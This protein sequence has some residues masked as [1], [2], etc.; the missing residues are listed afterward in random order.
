MISITSKGQSCPGT[1]IS[2]VPTPPLFWSHPIFSCLFPVI[3][4]ESQKA[5]SNYHFL[6]HNDDQMIT[7]P[8]SSFSSL[9]LSCCNIIF[10]VNKIFQKHSHLRWLRVY[11]NPI[12]W[13]IFSVSLLHCNFN[14]HRLVPPC[15]HIFSL[16]NSS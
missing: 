7:S 9:H 6:K 15:T 10:S 8:N 5:L 11:L 14:L 1:H 4:L 2:S 13:F 3:I 16:N 12:S